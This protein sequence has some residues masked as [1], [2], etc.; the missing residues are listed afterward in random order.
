[1]NFYLEMIELTKFATSVSLKDP[2]EADKM[3]FTIL[4]HSTPPLNAAMTLT[5]TRMFVTWTIHYALQFITKIN[6][7][8]SCKIMKTSIII[9]IEINNSGCSNVIDQKFQIILVNVPNCHFEKLAVL[10]TRTDVTSSRIYT[11]T[12]NQKTWICNSFV[13]TDKF[14]VKT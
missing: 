10:R 7:F 9:R 6:P 12:T 2:Y 4:H 13:N 3:G 1:M 14:H 11:N 8:I 5:V